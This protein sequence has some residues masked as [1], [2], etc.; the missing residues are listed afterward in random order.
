MF[1]VPK[2]FQFQYTDN[3]RQCGYFMTKLP[4]SI[5]HINVADPERMQKV[6]GVGTEIG[7]K[8][9]FG[10]DT[11]G[12]KEFVRSVAEIFSY[13][14]FVLNIDG[15][16]MEWIYSEPGFYL[17]DFDKVACFEFK[18]GFECI[19]KLDDTTY[20]EKKFTSI[21]KI[22]FFLFTAM[23]S[24]LMVPTRNNPELQNEFIAGYAKYL[25]T[26]SMKK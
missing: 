19:R 16:D 25:D 10:K 11:K 5:V 6:P 17:I 15:N 2:A 22:A 14:H 13:M 24:M 26:H 8:K 4:S 9:F 3:R 20:E 7:I 1:S 12:A 23:G 21:N 18:L